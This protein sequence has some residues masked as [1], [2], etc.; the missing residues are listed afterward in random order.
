MA[1]LATTSVLALSAC[2][3]EAETGSA[4]F[5]EE[6]IEIIIG[7]DAG[8]STDVNTRALAAAAE[9]TCDT[10]IIISNQPGGSGAIALDAV[11]RAEPDGY[12]LGTTPTEI[13]ALEHMGLS[14]VTYEDFAPV[15]RFILDPHGFFVRPDSPYQSMADVIEAAES[16]ERIR[17][18]TSGPASPYAITFQDVARTA[19]VSGQLVNV[20]FT[21]DAEAIPAVLGG[22][23]DVLVSNA[24]NV[25]G[26]VESGD[27]LPLAVAGEERIDALPDTPTL[28][29]EGIDVEGGSIYGLAAPADT[30]DEVVDI[31]D[32]CFG[33]AYA[34]EEFQEFL[35]SQN[36]NGSY[37][38]ADD[39]TGYLKSEYER[40]GGLLDELGL[41]E[42]S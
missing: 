42:D 25:I 41:S 13:S 1:A 39:F 38:D 21:G 3:A 15:L 5:P 31:L 37:L 35:E 24:S 8:G 19:G 33:K 17:I 30:P 23:V 40:Y 32:E 12:T 4:D 6:T 9:E 18:A 10:N 29:E 26:Q 34:S 11:R 7:F 28:Q 22:E 27:L 36:S 16:G 2:G 20:P 14:D